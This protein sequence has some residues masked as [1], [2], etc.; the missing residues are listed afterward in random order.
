M[1]GAGTPASGECLGPGDPTAWCRPRRQWMTGPRKLR[2]S[3]SCCACCAWRAV[4]LPEGDHPPNPVTGGRLR[5]ARE[6]QPPGPPRVLGG[7]VWKGSR[8]HRNPP[9]LDDRRPPA[10]LAHGDPDRDWCDLA[11]WIRAEAEHRCGDR[12]ATDVHIFIASLSPE[13]QR[14]LQTA[15]RHG[16]IENALGH[17]CRLGR[18]RQAHP[19]RHTAHN[20]A[21]P[22]ASPTTC[23]GRTGRSR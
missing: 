15:R 22:D 20:M 19:H 4:G 5:A 23:Y 13:A 21:I 14:R 8:A 6:G 7:H 17:G 18:G 3:R 2:L 12:V 11:S 16:S 1:T 10:C 9:L